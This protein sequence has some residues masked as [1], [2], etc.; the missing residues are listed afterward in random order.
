MLRFRVLAQLF[1]AVG[2]R[3]TMTE[4]SLFTSELVT[5]VDFN[6]PPDDEVWRSSTFIAS[7]DPLIV[8]PRCPVAI[9]Q[10]TGERI[11]ATPNLVMLYNPAQ[12][13]QRELRDSKGDSCV[14]FRLHPRLL[15][16]LERDVV[17]VAERRLRGT[18]APSTRVDYLRQHLLSRY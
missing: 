8:F 6:C 7:P 16:S 5:I 9:R 13:F 2:V 3:W 12:E 11:L 17:M 18:H 15:D 14:Y 1:A 4:R 10:A